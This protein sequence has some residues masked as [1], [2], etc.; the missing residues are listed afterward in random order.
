[1]STERAKPFVAYMHTVV[2]DRGGLE[3]STTIYKEPRGDYAAPVVVTP[4]LP[5]DPRVG[6]TWRD[7]RYNSGLY[8]NLEI[9]GAPYLLGDDEW[10]IGTRKGARPI[11]WLRR[12]PVM[13]TYRVDLHT[14]KQ[15]GIRLVDPAFRGAFVEVDAT[16]REAAL[17][18][19][20]ESLEEVS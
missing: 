16:S 2:M 15:H 3:S 5:D 13:K 20:A 14:L 18:K 19:L 10:C 6:E 1:M 11:K 12:L 9:T 17:A 7:S 4:L 8:Q